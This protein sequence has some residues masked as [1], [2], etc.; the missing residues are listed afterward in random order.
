M[1]K[2]SPDTLFQLIHS[3]QKAEKRHFKLYVK[4]NSAN[5][6]LKI[7]RLFDVID[8]QG[9]YDERL[10]LKKL[11]D[12]QKQ[13]L[14][15]LKAHLYKQILSALRLLK[16]SDSIDLQLNEFFDYAHIL[17]KKGLFLQSLVIIERA[18]QLARANQKF[19]FLIP[20]LALE[21][22]IE[23]LHITRSSEDRAEKLSAESLEVTTHIHYITLLSNLSLQLYAWYIKWGH[24]LNE[25]DEKTVIRFMKENVPAEA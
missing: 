17:Y 15:N 6:D 9:E 7:L 25:P 5:T 13:Q 20:A 21:K 24:A 2:F 1:S 14:S 19:N 16:S 3:L 12:I 18:K 4:R 22:R 23:S 11:P 8:K 10:L